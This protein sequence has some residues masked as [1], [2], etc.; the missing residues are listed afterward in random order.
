MEYQYIDTAEQLQTFAEENKNIT[1]I[2]F[3]TEFVGEK[4]FAPLLCLIHLEPVLD[5][6]PE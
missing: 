1:W 4:R 5:S 2:A 6:P 3:D